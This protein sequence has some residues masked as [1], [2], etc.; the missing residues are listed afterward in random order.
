MEQYEI[1][2][3]VQEANQSLFGYPTFV[4]DYEDLDDCFD[5]HHE[6]GECCG[7]HGRNDH[8]CCGGHHHEDGEGHQCCGDH[9]EEDECCGGHHHEDG[10]CGDHRTSRYADEWFGPWRNPEFCTF[11]FECNGQSYFV[12]RWGD[13]AD[14]PVLLLHGFM[15]TGD[16][17]W[18][19]APALAQDHCVY[20]LDLLGHGESSKPENVEEYSLAGQAQAIAELIRRVIRPASQEA[21]G[22]ERGERVHVVG[23]SLGGRVAEQLMEVCGNDIYTLTLESASLGPADEAE[24]QEFATRSAAWAARLRAEGMEPFVNWWEELPLFESQ[25]RLGVSPRGKATRAERLSQDPFAMAC[26]AEGMG[27]HTM[28][29]KSETLEMLACSWNPICYLFGR[30]DQKY[31]DKAHDFLHEGYEARGVMAGHN[32]HLEN[33]DNY[34]QEL[35]SFLH[36]NEMRGI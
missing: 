10:C 34:V 6:G 24:S 30:R 29:L 12:R 4:P 9:G 28:P 17:W 31:A 27:Q 22:K 19:V 33:P 15:Q 26:V 21:T 5:H 32:V 35:L 2:Q 18:G 3:K 36:S 14:I 1:E 25:R 13:P 23:Y 16:S 11:A 8:E 20:A 7:G